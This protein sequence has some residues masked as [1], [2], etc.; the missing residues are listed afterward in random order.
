MFLRA[1]VGLVGSKWF[2]YSNYCRVVL[3]LVSV[4]FPRVKCVPS[5][6]RGPAGS[7]CVVGTELCCRDTRLIEGRDVR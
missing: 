5:E 2:H 4:A 7:S 6:A 3:K 1:D